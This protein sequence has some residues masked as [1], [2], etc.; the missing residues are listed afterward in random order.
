[1]KTSTTGSGVG[2]GRPPKHHQFKAGESGN[3][4]GRPKGVRSL[5]SDLRDE[6]AELVSINHGE[7]TIEVTRQRAVVKAMADAALRGDLRA[8]SALLTLCSRALSDRDAATDQ[9]D[10]DAADQAIAAASAQRQHKRADEPT[11]SKN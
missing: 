1:M 7:R 3:P 8:A 9:T 6:M 5:E 10:P 2:Y 4:S 11:N